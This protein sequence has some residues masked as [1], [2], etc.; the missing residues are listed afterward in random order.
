MKPNLQQ[1]KYAKS[2]IM[3][4]RKYK[5]LMVV[6][7]SRKLSHHVKIKGELKGSNSN[8]SAY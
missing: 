1:I 8:I 2:P 5:A 4:L 7:D 3:M 6:N